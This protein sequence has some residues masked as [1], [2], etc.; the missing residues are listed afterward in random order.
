MGVFKTSIGV[1][2]PQAREY[3]Y[4]DAWVDTGASHSMLPASLLEQTLS[5]T[6]HEERLFETSDGCEH[7]YGYGYALFRIEGLEGPAPVVFGPEDQY[8]LG[9]TTMQIFNLAVDPGQHRLVPIP[10]LRI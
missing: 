7:R 2:H 1:A 9:A 4:V 10:R 3:H 6:P 8:L 5:L